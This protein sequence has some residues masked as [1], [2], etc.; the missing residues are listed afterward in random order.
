MEA[1]LFS[2]IKEMNASGGSLGG[3]KMN[4]S[5]QYPQQH[6]SSKRFKRRCYQNQRKISWFHDISVYVV[7]RTGVMVSLVGIFCSCSLIL[8]HYHTY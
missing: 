6:P 1:K 5:K 4:H 8:L 2:M 3:N 7:G